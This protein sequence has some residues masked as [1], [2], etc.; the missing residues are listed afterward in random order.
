MEVKDSLVVYG[1]LAASYE[2]EWARQEHMITHRFV[3][4][5]FYSF[6][7]LF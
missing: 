5:P 6:I 4:H 2:A 3:N 7:F 1:P